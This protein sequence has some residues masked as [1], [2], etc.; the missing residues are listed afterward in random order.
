MTEHDWQA[1]TQPI[2]FDRKPT[3]DFSEESLKA[4]DYSKLDWDVEYKEPHIWSFDLSLAIFLDKGLTGLMNFPYTPPPEGTERARN[5]F[6]RYA[7][8]DDLAT[9]FE[10]IGSNDYDDLLWALDWLKTYFTAL[11]T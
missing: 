11:W 6:R 8:K 7:C 9:D 3:D 10:K 2:S 1:I 4:P 5:V